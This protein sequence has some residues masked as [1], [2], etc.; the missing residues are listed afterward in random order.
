MIV[1]TG[2]MARAFSAF[3]DR[4]DLVLF[5]SGVS[6]STERSTQ[7]FERELT[8][9]EKTIESNPEALLIYFGT[10]SVFDADRNESA[11][12]QHKLRMEAFIAQRCRTWLVLR[13]GLAIGPTRGGTTLHEFLLDRIVRG[14]PFEVWAG[15]VRYPI[16]VEDVVHIGK[17]LASND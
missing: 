10:C 17:F 1:G 6:N 15:A 7:A 12:V 5:A 2:L 11:Y 3:Q 16:D 13:L 8:L 14:E 9:L 4:P